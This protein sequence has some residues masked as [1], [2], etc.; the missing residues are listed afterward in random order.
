MFVSSSPTNCPQSV[1]GT[2]ARSGTDADVVF[3]F[4]TTDIAILCC[5][6]GAR[7]PPDK[8]GSLSMTASAATRSE[9]PRPET[10]PKF[11]IRACES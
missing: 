7:E 2:R 1:L 9:E 6:S 4:A 8:S 11:Q 10:I 5:P 3:L